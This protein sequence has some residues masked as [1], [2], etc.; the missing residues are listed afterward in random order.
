MLLLSQALV[1][2]RRGFFLSQQYLG[3]QAVLYLRQSRGKSYQES[4]SLWF[5]VFL[6]STFFFDEP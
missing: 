4:L 3:R 5:L 2:L 1:L 6:L